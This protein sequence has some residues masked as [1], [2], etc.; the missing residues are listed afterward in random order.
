MPDKPV[1]LG[2]GLVAL[3]LVLGED[4]EAPPRMFAGGTCGNVLTILSF[5][6]WIAYPVARLRPGLAAEEVRSDMKKFGV[7]LDFLARRRQGS[8]PIIVQRIRRRPD[9]STV[10]RFAWSCPDCGSVLPG[11][12]PL[13]Q[14]E[15]AEVVKRMSRPSV[16]FMDR[17]SRGM[18]VLAEKS[19]DQG[20]L[21][22]FEPSGI[23]D[24]KLFGEAIALCHILKHS[25]ERAIQLSG[26]WKKSG[27]L[28]E[29][30]TL[31]GEGLRYRAR[32]ASETLG[33]WESIPAFSAHKLVDAAG[34]G[35]WC[36]AGLLHKVGTRGREG[37][38]SLDSSE[39]HEALRFGQALATWNCQFIGARGGMYLTLREEVLDAAKRIQAGDTV[40]KPAAAQEIREALRSVCPSCRRG[41]RLRTGHLTSVR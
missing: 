6:G 21:V 32:A 30:E 11:Y 34:C 25:R 4:A 35:D 7:K 26:K 5:L 39:I 33:K 10:H 15:A 38:A 2:S 1:V 31:G 9:G 12:K 18:L 37:F 41:G 22:M 17:V 14:S 19:R 28:L 29:V 36:T 13:L 8:T 40:D 23:G 20:A 3:D 27:P 24:P 16:F